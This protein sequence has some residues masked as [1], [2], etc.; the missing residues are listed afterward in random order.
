VNGKCVCPEGQKL[1]PTSNSC[2]KPIRKTVL[3]RGAAKEVDGKCV[4]P[5]GQKLDPRY[6][7]CTP[8]D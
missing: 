7:T 3:C 1:D 8:V 4:C 2:I 6:N 5:E